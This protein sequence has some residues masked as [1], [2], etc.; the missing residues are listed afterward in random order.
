MRKIS[1]SVSSL[2]SR[3][4]AGLLALVGFGCS[5]GDGTDDMICMYGTPTGSF[6]VK[7]NVVD[8]EGTPVGDAEIIVTGPEL[9]SSI[10]KMATVKT[11]AEGDYSIDSKSD[12]SKKLKVVCKPTDPNLE[13]D[14]TIVNLEYKTPFPNI[15]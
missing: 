8:S 3:F 13:A 12:T 1:V 9:P 6:E 5:D 2:L 15:C 10:W 11:D 7:G 4:C 14:S